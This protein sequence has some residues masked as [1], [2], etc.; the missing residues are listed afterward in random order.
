M[1]VFLFTRLYYYQNSI[2][3][4]YQKVKNCIHSSPVFNYCCCRCCA[5]KREW[6]EAVSLRRC[7][8]L[9]TTSPMFWC[10]FCVC[11]IARWPNIMFEND[12]WKNRVSL[13][14]SVCL[15]D[16]KIFAQSKK[17]RTAPFFCLVT[18]KFQFT[19]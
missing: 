15:L 12:D 3:K 9:P 1:L 11:D 13:S 2:C 8:C 5:H 6:T 7:F 14:L 17:M 19:A 10:K 4:M 18:V 16:Y